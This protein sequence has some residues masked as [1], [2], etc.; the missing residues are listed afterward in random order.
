MPEL[1]EDQKVLGIV[2]R[3]KWTN[4]NHPPGVGY[5]DKILFSDAHRRFNKNWN[6]DSDLPAVGRVYEEETEA[7]RSST[8]FVHHSGTLYLADNRTRYGPCKVCGCPSP[9]KSCVRCGEEKDPEPVTDDGDGECGPQPSHD[10][11]PDPVFGVV[12][13][14]TGTPGW[15][16][17]F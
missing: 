16:F 8:N 4:H 6:N 13:D 12:V 9:T 5:L 11:K 15:P 2:R 7:S 1:P 3:P 14:H 10:P 17:D